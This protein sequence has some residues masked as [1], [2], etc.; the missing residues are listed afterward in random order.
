VD[1]DA[2]TDAVGITGRDAMLSTVWAIVKRDYDT[3]F[4]QIA[5]VVR[6]SKDLTVFWQ[7][8]IALYRDL[9]VVKTTPEHAA[10]YLDLTDSETEQMKSLAN[11]LRKET[12]LYHC[13][14]LEDALFGMLK[15]NAVK[16]IVAEMTLVRMCDEALDDSR[17]AILSRIA[18]LEEQ[19]HTGAPRVAIAAPIEKEAPPATTPSAP[20]PTEAVPTKEPK[21]PTAS[22]ATAV[23]SPKTDEKVLRP[24][25][26][27]MEIVDRVG[28]SDSMTA[29]FL[30]AAAA[31]AT[32]SGEILILCDNAFAIN[33]LQH[34][35]AK[36]KLR[37]ALSA[38]LRQEL[39]ED[40]IKILPREEQKQ[41]SVIDELL[42]EGE[43]PSV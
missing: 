28:R 19:M 36:D 12:L 34:G 11:A 5:E 10:S 42:G 20:H 16:R 6:S 21:K 24:M 25:R 33:M 1:V 7:D 14:L 30:K 32:P 17:E 13:K 18:L 40:R 27:W 43:E 41:Y 4:G 26:N 29:S 37:A 23:E 15:A 2:V 39:S 22:P 35:A 3:L 9:L 8:L 31:Y 38:V